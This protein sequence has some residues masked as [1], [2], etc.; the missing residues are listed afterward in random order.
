MSKLKWSR[1]AQSRGLSP[2]WWV[3]NADTVITNSSFTT[4]T[5]PSPNRELLHT[6]LSTLRSDG[7]NLLATLLLPFYNHLSTYTPSLP[8]IHLNAHKRSPFF[9]SL[10]ALCFRIWAPKMYTSIKQWKQTPHL[11]IVSSVK[12][13]VSCISAPSFP[14]SPLSVKHCREHELPFAV[15]LSG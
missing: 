3:K 5:L 11:P 1:W 10:A 9:V 2:T 15:D 13:F 6:L 4:P 8:T 14:S 7:V 12:C